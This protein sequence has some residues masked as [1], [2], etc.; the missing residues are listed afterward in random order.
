V[1]APLDLAVSKVARYSEQDQIDI[2]KLGEAGLV[3]VDAFVTRAQQAPDY[4]VGNV[5]SVETSI[6]L[7]SEKLKRMELK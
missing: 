5:A 4:F 6:R 2:I 1:L 3:K 7:L